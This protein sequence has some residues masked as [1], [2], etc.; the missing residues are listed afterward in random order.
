VEQNMNKNKKL[1]ENCFTEEQ[2]HEES[3]GFEVI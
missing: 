1:Q 2:K 3:L